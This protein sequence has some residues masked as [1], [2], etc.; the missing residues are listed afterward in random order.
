[1]LEHALYAETPPPPCQ[2]LF[3]GKPGS[4]LLI[5]PPRKTFDSYSSTRVFILMLFLFT[6]DGS[7]PHPFCPPLRISSMAV[8]LRTLCPN[9]S[10]LALISSL[11][12]RPTY[13]T[14]R[15]ASPLGRPPEPIIFA[16]KLAPPAYFSQPR[17]FQSPQWLYH[18][19]NPAT[20]ESPLKA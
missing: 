15:L 8:S 20:W 14:M 11:D 16:H 2:H 3:G 9:H 5:I 6:P 1:M 13:S 7:Y 12:P 17:L 4:Q 10:L 19:P 18:S